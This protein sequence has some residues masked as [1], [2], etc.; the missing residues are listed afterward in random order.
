MYYAL[1]KWNANELWLCY[2]IYGWKGEWDRVYAELDSV[3]RI[4]IEIFCFLPERWYCSMPIKP[5]HLP[6]C[7]YESGLSRNPHRNKK[8]KMLWQVNI[9]C[10]FLEWIHHTFFFAVVSWISSLCILSKRY[11][12]LSFNATL[13]W[14]WN[15]GYR[16]YFFF[17]HSSI[18]MKYFQC[19]V[20]SVQHDVHIF[21]KSINSIQNFWTY[22]AWQWII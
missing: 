16:F 5:I 11:G 4:Q 17:C 1:L 8:G 13:S 15:T 14:K 10:H 9:Q 21:L 18:H 2:G 6:V 20:H 22:I 12:C 19:S 3:A 7:Q